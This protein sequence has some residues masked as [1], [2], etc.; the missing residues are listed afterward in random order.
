MST[1]YNI[2][3]TNLLFRHKKNSNIKL[4]IFYGFVIVTTINI[5][6]LK[7]IFQVNKQKAKILNNYGKTNSYH[8]FNFYPT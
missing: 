5:I 7:K 6:Q 2:M 1:L 3:T 4:L 8:S